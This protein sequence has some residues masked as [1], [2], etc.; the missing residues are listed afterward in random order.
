MVASTTRTSGGLDRRARIALACCLGAGFG[1]LLDSAVITYAVPSATLALDADV[2]QVQWFLAAYSLTFGLGLVPA[3]RIGDRYG[4]RTPLIIGLIVFILGGLLSAAAPHIWVSVAGRALQGVGAGTISAQVLGI[5]QDEFTGLARVRA[6][7]GYSIA[8]S[9]SA[10]VGPLLSGT[11]LLMLPAEWTW[12]GILGLHLPFLVAT[13]VAAWAYRPRTPATDLPVTTGALGR[14]PGLDLPAV[15]ALGLLVTLITL[16]VIDPVLS[17]ASIWVLAG[18]GPLLV[19]FLIWWERAYA[20]RGIQP[21]FVPE[22]LASRGFVV[23]NLVAA[24]WFGAVL[25]KMTVVTLHLL[26]HTD[27]SPLWVA[28]V[29]IPG[30]VARIVSSAASSSVY[31][32]FGAAALPI[33]LGLEVVAVAILLVGVLLAD[34]QPTDAVLIALVMVFSVLSGSG[35]GVTE[36]ILRAATLSFAPAGAYGVAAAFLQLTQRLSSTFFVAL[37]SGL[38]LSGVRGGFVSALGVSA[39][40]AACAAVLS[41]APDLRRAR[42]ASA[43]P[44]PSR[45]GDAAEQDRPRG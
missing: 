10:I 22:L 32:R 29:L 44:A 7:S 41:L 40:A 34:H 30:A 2:Q 42:L 36:P 19:V 16:P 43:A 17:G 1:T 21:L 3:G 45:G 35:S 25:A 18:A 24:L 37:A 28:V 26:A 15:A 6:L 27:L 23:G 12:R 11:L 14:R 8:S 39:G 9:A 38:L 5:I 4:R 20:R 31:R 13:L 33:S